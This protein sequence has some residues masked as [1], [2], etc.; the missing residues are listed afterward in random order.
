LT[1]PL[2][3][4]ASEAARYIAARAAHYSPR[5]AVVLGSGLGGVADAI[6]DPVEIAYDEVPHFATS[7]VEGHAGKLIV[8]SCGGTDVAVMKGRFHFYEGYSMEE[9]TLPVRVFSLMGIRSLVLTNAAGGLSER[10]SPGR[11]MVIADHINM[12]GDNPLRGA[13]DERFGPRFPDMT[14]AYA[15]GYIDIA[16]EVAREIG[17]ELAEGVYMALRGPSYETPAEIRMMRALGADA[18][19]MSTAPEVIVARHS[20]MKV[21]AI[22]CITNVAAGMTSAEIDHSEVMEVGSRAGRQL[23]DLIVRVIPR[24]VGGEP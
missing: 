24:L 16:H 6:D 4:R 2:Y 23:A 1:I 5:V 11:L 17:V 10:L 13:N 21:L 18:V 19:G 20:G 3:E 22:S 15:Q 9:V 14:A 12:M 7:T 8:G